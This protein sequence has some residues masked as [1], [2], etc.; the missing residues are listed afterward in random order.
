MQSNPN[1]PLRFTVLHHDGIP[2]PHYDLLLE[3]PGQDPLATWQIR[4]SP[5]EWGHPGVLLSAQRIADHR[6]LYLDYEG[7]ISGHRGHVRRVATGTYTLLDQ[8]ADQWRIRLSGTVS[9][10][11][12][13]PAQVVK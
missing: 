11:L 2:E 1:Q 13:L 12:L 8:S 7:P 5:E 9:A 4:I 6:R 10:E 3:L